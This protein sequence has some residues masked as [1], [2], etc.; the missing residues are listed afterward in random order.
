MADVISCALCVQGESENVSQRESQSKNEIQSDVGRK[1][2]E[3]PTLESER[4]Q[5]QFKQN[6]LDGRRAALDRIEWSSSRMRKDTD[7]T[8]TMASTSRSSVHFKC[9]G[10]CGRSRL[11]REMERIP[12]SRCLTMRQFTEKKKHEFFKGQA[13]EAYQSLRARICDQCVMQCTLCK[14]NAPVH[15]L[16][17]YGACVAC[18]RKEKLQISQNGV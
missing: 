16:A 13:W 18:A 11:D 5:E 10:G 9:D 4:Q 12:F 8:H 6:R 15:T 1:E 3:L 14:E 17:K 2:H 7:T